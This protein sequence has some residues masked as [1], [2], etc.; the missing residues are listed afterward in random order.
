MA[1]MCENSVLGASVLVTQ[2]TRQRTP[3]AMHKGQDL[4]HL[5]REGSERSEKAI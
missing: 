1:V 3:W 2:K 5:R 4:G